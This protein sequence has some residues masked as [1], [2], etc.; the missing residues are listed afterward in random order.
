MA[1]SCYVITDHSLLF[2]VQIVQE[3]SVCLNLML[4]EHVPVRKYHFSV[5]VTK[6]SV[7]LCVVLLYYVIVNLKTIQNQKSHI[8]RI[9]TKK[10]VKM[11]NICAWLLMVSFKVEVKIRVL[12]FHN[13][14]LCMCCELQCNQPYD[15]FYQSASPTNHSNVCVISLVRAN[16]SG[17]SNNS[18]LFVFNPTKR[19]HDVRQLRTTV[20][21]SI[22]TCSNDIKPGRV[23]ITLCGS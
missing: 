5:I 10:G 6:D 7:A 3:S 16:N 11:E 19:L 23:K 4:V 9:Q 18:A 13:K 14:I 17:F 8:V 22:K 21:K 1:E 15:N 12:I 2:Q 20:Q